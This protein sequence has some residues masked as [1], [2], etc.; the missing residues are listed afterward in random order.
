MEQEDER[1]AGLTDGQNRWARAPL[2]SFDL[3]SKTITTSRTAWRLGRLLQ[4]PS[5]TSL[6]LI[7]FSL[8]PSKQIFGRGAKSWDSWGWQSAATLV[9]SS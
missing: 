8:S 3:R 9:S 1:S 5:I 2:P 4:R 7:T 6:Q